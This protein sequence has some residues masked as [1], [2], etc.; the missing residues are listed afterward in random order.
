[1]NKVY[2]CNLDALRFFAALMVIISHLEQKKAT[3]GFYNFRHLLAIKSFGEL[4]VTLFFVLSG[5]LITYLLYAEKKKDGKINI[6]FFYLRRILRIWPLYFLIT[7]LGFAVWPHFHFFDIP[8][9]TSVIYNH[10]WLKLILFI[11]FQ[12][13]LAL[14]TFAPIPYTS[15]LWSVGVEEQFYLLWPLIIA[16]SR[17]SLY[18]LIGILLF[19]TLSFHILTFTSLVS[20][21]GVIGILIKKF[22]YYSR[23]DSMAIGALGA[24][25][26]FY[27]KTRALSFLYSLPVQILTWLTT[28]AFMAFGVHSPLFDNTIY[29]LLFG[30]IILN[31]AT[32]PRNLVRLENQSIN[33][34][35]KISYGL[36]MY[37]LIFITIAIK[38][39]AYLFDNNLSGI[40]PIFFCFAITMGMTIIT[41]SLSYQYIEKP[42]IKRKN[43]FT[44]I[45]SRDSLGVYK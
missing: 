24:Y 16:F 26:V 45:H 43:R 4:G 39:S 5:F 3:L 22:F 2:F 40:F 10:L 19:V 36:Y 12:P 13:N 37:H 33:Y 23:F 34:L 44:I 32:N 14:M 35:G 29:S 8:E 42:F 31:L 18:W 25:M 27:N 11:F 30:I 21:L 38:F 20:N 41:A 17:K 15:H 9:W 7:F 28:L 6:P 1:L